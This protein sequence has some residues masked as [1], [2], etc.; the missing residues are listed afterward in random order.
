MLREGAQES[1][2]TKTNKAANGES[3]ARV[4]TL[5][6]NEDPAGQRRIPTGLEIFE[7]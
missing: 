4:E 1:T 7:L 3:D 2:T 5:N 6:L